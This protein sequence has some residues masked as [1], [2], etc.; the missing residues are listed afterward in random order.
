MEDK[1]RRRFERDEFE[2][3]VRMRG[4]DGVPLEQ[5]INAGVDVSMTESQKEQKEKEKKEE[6]A[7]AAKKQ[8][9]K[10]AGQRMAE[11]KY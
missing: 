7:Q 9:A 1:E 10:T 11:E 2:Q 5:L 3:R 8:P 4:R 6:E